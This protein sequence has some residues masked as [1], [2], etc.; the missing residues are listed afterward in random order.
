[1]SIS[2]RGN[3]VDEVSD[4]GRGFVD[5]GGDFFSNVSGSGGSIRCSIF[6]VGFGIRG[7]VF[8]GGLDVVNDVFSVGGEVWGDIVDY[9]VDDVVSG[10]IFVIVVLGEGEEREESEDGGEF[11]DGGLVVGVSGLCVCWGKWGLEWSR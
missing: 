1:M 7:N 5:G 3:W 11:Y 4:V 2:F 8:D 6:N 10:V 9:I